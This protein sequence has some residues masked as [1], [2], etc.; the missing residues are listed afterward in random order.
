MTESTP[1]RTTPDNPAP[2]HG[3]MIDGKPAMPILISEHTALVTRTAELEAALGSILALADECEARG[4]GSGHPLT[5]TR[6]RAI[7]PEPGPATTQAG[8]GAEPAPSWTPPPPGNR[9]EQ[10]PDDVLAAIR[11]GPYLST[12]CHAAFLCETSEPTDVLAGWSERLHARCRINNKFTGK[13]CIC[14]CH[15]EETL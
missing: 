13:R 10:L 8:N 11:P 4:H 3:C 15:A 7:L 12:A 5:V 1:A 9:R 6:V 14:R 2:A